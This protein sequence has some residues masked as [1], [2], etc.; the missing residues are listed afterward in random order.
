MNQQSV[1]PVPFRITIGVTGHRDIQSDDT[2]KET[3]DKILDEIQTEYSQQSEAEIRFCVL[4]PLAE[5][6]DRIV[7]ETVLQRSDAIL[8]VVL[9]MTLA[10]YFEDFEQENSHKQF[11]QLYNQDKSPLSLRNKSLKDEFPQEMIRVAKNQ[12]YRDVGQFVV[13]HC[14]YLIAIFD[15]TLAKGVGGTGEIVDYA[16]E[17]ECPIY[18]IHPERASEFKKEE[19][20]GI[21]E[22]LFQNIQK[23]NLELKNR[24][25]LEPD[26]QNTFNQFFSYALEEEDFHDFS[27]FCQKV[28]E[29]QDRDSTSAGVKIWSTLSEKGRDTA[30]KIAQKQKVYRLEKYDFV[31]ELNVIINKANLF[32][33]KE[34]QN[35]ELTE[36]LQKW[37]QEENREGQ[38]Q[39][40][41]QK[42]NR[43]VLQSEFSDT[44]KNPEVDELPTGVKTSVKHKLL[45]YFTFAD[46]MALKYQK[47]YQRVG[48]WVFLLAFLAVA[49][50]G[51]GSIFF[52]SIWWVIL[53]E[54][55]ILCSINVLI[56][57]AD[58][59]VRSHSQYLEFR[60][61]AERVRSFI[62]L[63]ACGLEPST[64]HL[65]RRQDEEEKVRENKWM[66]LA[67]QEIW[68]QLSDDEA[69]QQIIQKG[70]V[71]EKFRTLSRYVTKK[72]L[73]DQIRYHYKT[74]RRNKK[75]SNSFENSGEYIF[76][77]AII[78]ALIHLLVS[79]W[80]PHLIPHYLDQL[81]IFLALILPA[82]A[83]MCEAI[84]SHREFRRLAI[85]S[86]R[87]ELELEGLKKNFTIL[88][89]EKYEES[90]RE[91][92]QKLLEETEDW[93]ALMSYANLYKAV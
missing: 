50:V 85:R 49:L 42:M 43:S 32:E 1:P 54:L 27:V 83:A 40:Q 28:I 63:A 62:N 58:S 41:I 76:Y 45:P 64:I 26:V 10:D 15:G 87:M 38:P 14:D 68:K 24:G 34:F 88:S 8:R 77:G 21:T 17:K 93:I 65:Y 69:W 19:G 35:Y 29:Q 59:V 81:L 47:I 84:R 46:S 18:I 4:S 33:L 39:L 89:L 71:N 51:F 22:Q 12:A 60:F 3:I 74:A 56:F 53:V 61:L 23:F 11:Y 25:V 5:G 48:L 7:A 55:I 92:N 30:Q 82:S 20:K 90:I 67:A 80:V 36:D 73:N 37:L 78:V 70:Y 44:L 72:C 13:D 91:I 16:R 9:P 79:F 6:A 31:D 66:L 75:M 2:I 57:W 52:E 86:Q